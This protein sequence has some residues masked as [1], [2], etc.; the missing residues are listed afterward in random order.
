MTR[1]VFLDRSGFDCLT[2]EPPAPQNALLAALD[3]PNVVV[4][5]HIAWGSIEASRLVGTQTLFLY[6]GIARTDNSKDL[7]AEQQI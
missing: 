6:I 4:T 7:I 3:R 1:I 5:P 2:M